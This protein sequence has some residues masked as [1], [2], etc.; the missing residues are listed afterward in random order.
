M[1]SEGGEYREGHREGLRAACWGVVGVGMGVEGGDGGWEW[2]G[3]WAHG[4]VGM[5]E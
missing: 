4:G 1:I 3:G 5:G 2:G